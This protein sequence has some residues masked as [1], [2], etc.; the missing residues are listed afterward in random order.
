LVMSIDFQISGS[1]SGSGNING[2]GISGNVKGSTDTSVS[3][4]HLVSGDMTLRD[5]I[6]ETFE[7]FV[8]SLEP[9][10]ATE[11]SSGDI[12]QVNFNGSLGCSLDVSYGIAN[13]NFSAP[14]VASVLDSVAKGAAQFTL[15]SGKIN[16]GADASVSYTHTDDFTV[17]VQKLDSSDAFLYVMRAHKNDE[18]ES[19]QVSAAVTITNTPGV[20]INS[21]ELEQSVNSIAGTGGDQ[22]AAYATDV[23][24]GL[25][26]KLSNWINNTVQK[27]ASLGL[28]W[29]Q[30]HSVSMLFKYQIALGDVDLVDRSWIA[31]CSGNLRGAVGMGGLIPEPGSGISDQLSRSFTVSLKFFN[32][33]SAADKTTYFK[34]TYVVVTAAGDLCYMFDI[35][36]ESDTDV[37]KSKRT[38]LIHFVATVNESTAATVS[39]AE[40]DLEIEMSAS[41]DQTEAGRIGDLVGF[42]PPN[43]QVNQAQK[44]MQQFV[45]GKPSGTLDLVCILKPS[46]YGRLSCSEYVGS[47]PPA[48]QQQDSENWSRFHDA[49][50]GLLNLGF[51]GS[52][53]YYDWQ[54]FNVLCVYGEGVSGV[55]DR[56]SV[57]NPAAVPPSFLSNIDAP[58]ALV[59][60][61]L[62]NSAEFMN[63]CDDLHQL[64]GLTSAPQT[65]AQDITIYNQLLTSLVELILKRDVNNDYSK[66]AVAALLGLAN[67]QDVAA[68]IS[69]ANTTLTCRITLS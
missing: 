2:L 3:F 26:A 10:C 16:I 66:P 14:G 31:L 56:H 11:M 7:T 60:Y 32:F 41:N 69:T 24:Q 63:L 37:N 39:N 13:V 4:C 58:A 23:A 59:S 30:H 6:E 29:D 67:P 57:G 50:V 42:I 1:A 45:S 5:A 51:L 22:A 18:S 55:P 17:I 19:L 33:F 47:K 49:S 8:F 68:A 34:N 27:G 25:N 15:P 43:Q 52:L 53:S 44:T 65:S 46:A 20:T 21:T 62:L 40:V 12:A 61:F 54:Q 9:S 28:D 48:N 64:A 38:C 35:G 36:K